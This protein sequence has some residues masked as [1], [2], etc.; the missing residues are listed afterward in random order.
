MIRDT[1]LVIDDSELDLAI[2]NEIFK[3]RFR[4]VCEM[5]A[6]RGLATLR[7]E[8]ARICAVLLDICLGR[9]GAGFTVLRQLQ[10]SRE[11]S[12]LPVIMITTDASEKY[13]RTGMEQGAVDFLVKPVDPHTVQE[14][15][16]A[17]VK[18]HWPP[19]ST[20]LDRLHS[21]ENIAPQEDAPAAPQRKSV[22]IGD[23]SV[24]E[25]AALAQRWFEKIERFCRYRPALDTE[26][27][28]QLGRLTACIAQGYVERH[29]GGPL[30]A[31]TAALIGLAAPFCDIGAVGL[32]SSMN[33]EHPEGDP[34]HPLLGWE[35]LMPS[36]DIPL[37]RLA[38]EI[39]L[40]HHRNADGSGFPQ[41][42]E[43]EAPLSAMLVHAAMRLQHYLHYFRGYEDALDRAISTMHGEIGSVITEPVYEA[44]EV[45]RRHLWDCIKENNGN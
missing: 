12:D 23:L 25:S 24:E 10:V 6:H 9:R 42:R 33:E 27:W 17:V 31:E 38:A 21:E 22:L 19:K 44:I 8:K 20:I 30:K 15:V 35:L 39:A 1:Q 2:L 45:A 7:Q 28:K 26:R 29:P 36:E 4:V 5:D 11:T 37:L 41:D 18:K 14:R 3:H 13:V 16:C 34:R 43:G 32:I 40:W